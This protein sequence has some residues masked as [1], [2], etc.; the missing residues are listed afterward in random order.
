MAPRETAMACARYEPLPRVM[1]REA[2]VAEF[3]PTIKYHAARIRIHHQQRAQKM[4][5]N[6]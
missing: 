5:S 4:R 6:N 1:D 2:V 3:I